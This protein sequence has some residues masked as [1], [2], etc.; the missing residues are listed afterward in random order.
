MNDSHG[1]TVNAAGKKQIRSSAAFALALGLALLLPGAA[2]LAASKPIP[3]VDII[4]RKKPGG[5]AVSVP[6]GADGAY[7]LKGLAP[8]NY[9]LFVGGQR[10]Q[11]IS[12]DKGTISG[13]LSREPDGKASIT[14]NGQV[15]VV[16][17]LPSAAINTTR[18]NIKKPPK[19]VEIVGDQSP[20]IGVAVGDVNGDGRAEMRT[21]GNKPHF[22]PDPELPGKL[23]VINNSETDT[24][25]VETTNGVGGTGGGRFTFKPTSQVADSATAET[26]NRDHIDQDAQ[27][28]IKKRTAVQTSG[29]GDARIRVS[30]DVSTL[31]GTAPPPKGG[32]DKLPGIAGDPIQGTSVGLEG[33]P[34]SIK[35]SAKTDKTGAFHF[36]KLPAGKYKLKLDGLPSQSLT[37]GADGIADGKVM[38]GP[39]GSKTIF[40]RWGNRIATF[41]KDGGSKAAEN[42]VGFGSGNNPMGAGTGMGAGPGM[43]PGMSP[44]AG[45]LVGG[46]GPSPM[47]GPGGAGGPGSPMR[48]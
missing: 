18:S 36:D 47:G 11:T 10:V 48:P 40:D 8:G 9:D 15:G 31:R 7:Q 30:A 16:S 20:E 28:D 38:R 41:P 14:F 29:P 1:G 34:G 2:A 43:R 13:V 42:P 24:A 39:D 46:P 21:A 32:D 27:A 25:T 33:D 5:N 12:I 22:E 6:T 45:G 17:D 3:D 26:S 44:G 37:V 19:V 23:R 35:V 4:V